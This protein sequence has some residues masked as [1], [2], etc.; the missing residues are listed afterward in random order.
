MTPAGRRT[1]AVLSALAAL[2]FAAPAVGAPRPGAADLGDPLD[3]GGGNGG[4]DV[5]LYD[6]DLRYET[7]DPGQGLEGDETILARATKSLSR[8]NLDFAGEGV[9]AVWV[10]GKRA[11]F[12]RDGDELVITPRRALRDGE[13]F[14]VRIAGFAAT[15][16]EPSDDPLSVVFFTTP[17][18]SATAPQ[19]YYARMIYPSNDHPRDKAAF[20]FDFDVP[21]G[22][23]A[24][25]NG[26]EVSNRTR[27]GRTHTTYV[28]R[29]PMATQLTQLAVGDWDFTS[30]GR[31]RGVILR[32][33]TAPSLT[34]RLLEPLSLGPSQ[35]DWLT[36]R[37][38][39]YP[40]DIYG[41]F[42]V[43]ADIG[44]ALETQTLSL[45]DIGWFDAPQ[46]VWDPTMVHELAHQWFGDDVALYEWSDLWLS[47]GHTSWYEFLYAEERGQLEED[48]TFWP[49]EQG[50]PTLEELMRAV[51]AHGDQWRHDFGPVARPSSG[52][53]ADLFSFNVYHG[54]ALVLYALR[55]KIGSRA[56]QRVERAWVDRYGGKSASTEDFIALASKVS[57]RNVT[58]FLRNWLYGETTPRMPGHSDWEVDPVVEESGLRAPATTRMQRRR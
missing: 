55:Q 58:G 37:V 17:D 27:G 56:F 11:R 40:F 18:G 36:E 30:P 50:Y 35:L 42:V 24:V 32:D 10:D 39:R 19:P 1:G 3:P 2:A 5:R 9:S 29:R 7:A 8:F 57:G 28:M 49:D 38:G 45:F 23:D 25:A 54:G 47:E 26:V 44:F 4:Y 51:Y 41:T 31:R 13:R 33:V 52:D 22:T 16:T 6:L 46:G 53:P 48:T 43:D 21:A 12:V 14:V 15:P 20:R 34:D